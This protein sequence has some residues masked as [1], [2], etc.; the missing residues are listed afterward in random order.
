ML[1]LYFLLLKGNH[2]HGVGHWS[3]TTW[4][5]IPPLPLT[6]YMYKLLNFSVPW[7]SPLP[8]RD[9]NNTFLTGLLKRFNFF[10][11]VAQLAEILVHRPGIEPMPLAVKAQNPN[12]WT[13]REFLKRFND[14]VSVKS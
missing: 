14:S 9:N 7:F 4:V 6:S 5:L 8:N 11:S 13:A 1:D 3:Q 12:H 2:P 10:F